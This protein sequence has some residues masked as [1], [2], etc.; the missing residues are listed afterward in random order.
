MGLLDYYV[1]NSNI[2]INTSLSFYENLELYP[3]VSYFIIYDLYHHN[4]EKDK[5]LDD[6]I[7]FGLI[8]FKEEEIKI[9][10]KKLA[11]LYKKHG[12]KIMYKRFMKE[13][14]LQK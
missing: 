10:S 2:K 14:T 7:E 1:D 6:W 11:C 3:D 4:I 8:D 13:Y 9:V 12:N 5:N